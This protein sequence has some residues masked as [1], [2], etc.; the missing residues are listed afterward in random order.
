[1]SQQNERKVKLAYTHYSF[2]ILN[3]NE[4]IIFDHI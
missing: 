2:A 3:K 1:M 4:L